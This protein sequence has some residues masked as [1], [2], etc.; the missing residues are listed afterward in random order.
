M[1]FRKFEIKD[2]EQVQRLYRENL[3]FKIDIKFYNYL[4]YREG[5]FYSS[6]CEADGSIVAHN[7]IIPR[8]YVSE[9]EQFTLGLFSGGMVNSVYSGIFFKLLSYC[10]KNFDGDG[11]IAFPNAN[12]EP[13]FTKLLKFGSINENY[14]SLK[15]N[16]LNLNYNSFHV[17][18]I[19]IHP[20]SLKFRTTK[21]PRNEYHELDYND[22]NIIYKKFNDQVDLMYVSA[23]NS[24]LVKLLLI[25]FNKGFKVINLIYG[26]SNEPIS[27]GFL[28][29]ENN[30]FCYKWYNERL[31]NLK[32]NCQMV[33]SDVF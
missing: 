19:R 8:Q 17:P 11:L 31:N 1:I 7:A 4:Y 10:I 32:F 27:L 16:N 13:F 15:K 33:D 29:N 28:K 24:D 23:F 18:D 3:N 21:H 2:F 26:N 20:E 14:F 9:N 30:T 22:T 25:L 6:V 12:S 5:E